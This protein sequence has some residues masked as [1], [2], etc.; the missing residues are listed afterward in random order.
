MGKKQ[1][2]E[3]TKPKPYQRTNIYLKPTENKV[4]IMIIMKQWKPTK[5]KK[6]QTHENTTRDH[7]SSWKFNQNP[8][9]PN[10]IDEKPGK[11]TKISENQEAIKNNQKSW[12]T[13][14]TNQKLSIFVPH[15]KPLHRYKTRSHLPSFRSAHY[16]S[17]NC[18]IFTYYTG[19]VAKV[20]GTDISCLERW[21][22][23]S[24]MIWVFERFHFFYL[25]TLTVSC[26]NWTVTSRPPC[27]QRAGTR[28][29]F[30]QGCA[31]SWQIIFTTIIIISVITRNLPPSFWD[32]S[33]V[34]PS[35][36][37]EEPYQDPYSGDQL[38]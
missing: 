13:R 32:S 2:T 34:S 11:S 19:D 27:L 16:L 9:R 8:Y 33:W 25:S 24:T 21:C 1:R 38:W 31:L 22:S 35:L 15:R 10:T 12:R 7:K 6:K 28:Y 29:L 26:R 30:R 37:R 3:K 17:A 5:N 23:V 36:P 4:K 14:T 18:V 20:S